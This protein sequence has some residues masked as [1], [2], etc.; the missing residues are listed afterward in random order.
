M[1]WSFRAKL[2]LALLLFGLLPTLIMTFVTYE[3]AGQLK[4]RIVRVIRCSTIFLARGLD[5][6]PLD[7]TKN[8]PT[9]V[10][11][12]SDIRPISGLFDLMIREIQI[13]NVRIALIA[14][15]L[16]VVIARAAPRRPGDLH[17][18]REARKSL[19]PVHP[20]G[21]RVARGGSTL[22]RDRRRSLGPR[23]H[24]RQLDH[25]AP[26]R[27]CPPGQVHRDARRGAERCLRADLLDPIQGHRGF[28]GLRDRY[29][30]PGP[31]AG[32]MVRAAPG[33]DHGGDPSARTGPSRRAGPGG[34]ERRASACCRTSSTW[35]SSGSP[36]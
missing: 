33:R 16:T 24:R 36:K 7:E 9:P 21:R 10:L 31:G 35:L 6:S 19:R 25:A 27:G 20:S 29:N 34:P 30:H 23:V 4:D 32:Q 14:P 1:K 11:N 8:G 5:R 18:R 26:A 22:L 13:P 28:P 15:D 2:V 17:Q 3:T 12:P